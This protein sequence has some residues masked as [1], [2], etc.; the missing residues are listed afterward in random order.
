MK[1]NLLQE[2]L[3]DLADNGK[4]S[5]DVRWVGFAIPMGGGWGW[6]EAAYIEWPEFEKIAVSHNYNDGYEDDELPYNLVIVGE[7]WWLRRD[8]YDGRGKWVF[9]QFIKPSKKIV[10]A[11]LRRSEWH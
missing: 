4:S 5:N 2:T 6:P 8:H 9:E 3:R 10:I 7:G 11:S 1:I